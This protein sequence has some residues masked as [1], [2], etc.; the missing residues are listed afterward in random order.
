MSQADAFSHHTDGIF[1]R[2][3]ERSALGALLDQAKSGNGS[4]VLIGGHAGIGKTTLADDLSRRAGE[5]GMLVLTGYC[6][7]LTAAPPYGPWA[8]VVRMAARTGVSPDPPPALLNEAALRQSTSQQALFQELETFLAEAAG[9]TPLALVL[10]D[11]HWA[12][13]ASLEFLRVL[14][15]QLSQL[16]VIVAVTYRDDELTLKH[17][18]YDLLPLLIREA[19]VHRISLR[20]LDAR[21]VSALVESRYRLPAGEAA[22]LADYLHSRAEGNPF[23][24]GEVLRTLEEEERLRRLAG[25]WEVGDLERVA[26]PPLVRQV[27]DG[28]LSRLGDDVRGALEV[29]AVIGQ[30]VPLALWS[31]V[32]ERAEEDLSPIVGRAI[33]AHLLE[34]A[35]DGSRLRF[36]HAL[37]REA[38]YEGMPLPRR[39]ALHRV[40]AEALMTRQGVAPDTIAYHL[41]EA[42]D[43]RAVEWFIQAGMRAERV[44]WLTAAEHLKSAL[45][46][47]RDLDVDLSERGWLIIRLVRL[48]RFSDQVVTLEYLEEAQRYADETGDRALAAYVLVCRGEAH[49]YQG[50]GVLGTEESKSGLTLLGNLSVEE[51][52]RLDS[53]IEQGIV[54]PD[55]VLVATWAAGFGHLGALAD[56]R[57]LAMD[58][59]DAAGKQ[60]RAVPAEV[61]WALG[62]AHAVSGDPTAARESFAQA[63]EAFRA[64]HDYVMAG[65]TA[66]ME[67]VM[68]VLVYETDDL[69]ARQRVIDE[70]VQAWTRARG[71]HGT[72]LPETIYLPALVL[73][74]EWTTAQ[75][76]L[77][78]IRSSQMTAIRRSYLLGLFARIARE[79]GD[80]TAAQEI[81]TAILPQGKATVPG[82]IGYVAAINGLLVAALIALDSHDLESS[83]EWLE[84]VDHWLEWNGAVYGRAETQLLWAIWQRA[85]GDLETVQQTA[86]QALQTA[87]TPRQPLTLLRIHR[88]L[89]E[90]DTSARRHVDAEA[91]LQESLRLAVA[92]AAPY[93]RA[94]TLIALAELR[95]ALGQPAEAMSL[96][97]DA[98]A[99]CER[100]HARPALERIAALATQLAATT[101]APEY[102]AGLSAREVEVLRLAARGLT[103]AQIGEQLYLSPRTVEHHLR[104]IYQKL[105]VSSRAA[106][107]RFAVEHDLV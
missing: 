41:R 5:R 37:V 8:Q 97:D 105:D 81:I 88:L 31:V 74:G 92:C 6:Y 3:R 1:G 95:L 10:E 80:H 48:L 67:L 102:P 50:K 82:M 93:E 23:F 33:D 58:A 40:T 21:A 98:R 65:S 79:Q 36:T 44:A 71:A 60:G 66:F 77:H 34:D 28:R 101:A 30:D 104:S 68:A 55:I 83:R 15:H 73:S 49:Y 38:L 91:H 85:S 62:L 75:E 11:M 42:G 78:M 43:A 69:D 14:G 52:R 24:L 39:R 94:L 16:P 89:G 20:P 17:P 25:G 107:T 22:R 61:P 45:R 76:Q 27:I 13:P 100:L 47:M 64:L 96:L 56:A 7:D 18:L 99:T 57:R 51:R 26:V 90:L 59:L 29:G 4:I 87:S 46:M 19:P 70:G 103:N 9:T 53:L 54:V 32:S 2:D 63:R 84:A 35:R 12:D 106:A 86:R 72:F